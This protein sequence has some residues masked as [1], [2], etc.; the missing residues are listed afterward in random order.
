MSLEAQ[1]RW[2]QE[3]AERGLCNY[4]GCAA[5]HEAG[6]KKCRV[7]LDVRAAQMRSLRDGYVADGKCQLCREKPLVAGLKHCQGCLDAEAERIKTSCAGIANERYY[8]LKAAG[9][10]TK[11]GEEPLV[12][13]TCCKSCREQYRDRCKGYDAKRHRIRK[14]RRADV[15]KLVFAHYGTTCKCCEQDWPIEMLQIGHIDD[16]VPADAVARRNGISRKKFRASLV[17][18]GFPPGFITLCANCHQAWW[19]SRCCPHAVGRLVPDTIDGEAVLRDPL[20]GK[21]VHS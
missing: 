4:P 8:R 14:A 17:E 10:C 1:R 16:R 21:V 12:D 11:C 2:R 5:K 7:H 15:N 9:L 6:R 20:T 3:Q 18:Q 19:Y 13:S